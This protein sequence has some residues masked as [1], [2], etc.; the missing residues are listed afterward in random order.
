MWKTRN[1]MNIQ[2]T[3]ENIAKGLQIV[4]RVA[5]TKS[6]LPILGNIL[7]QTEDG[8]LKLAATDLELGVTTFVRAKVEEEGSITLPAR[9]LVDFLANATDPTLTIRTKDQ[10]ASIQSEHYQATLKGM[11]ASEFPLI[12]AVK[13]ATTLT[14]ESAAFR[15]ALQD[16]LF[17]AAVDDT[18]PVL[19]GVC[20]V[21]ADRQLTLAATDSY[22]LAER[23]VALAE[24]ATG[25]AIIPSRT[26][27][28]L[29]RILPETDASVTVAL[30]ENQLAL[31]LEETSIVSRLIEGTF[32]N[33]SQIIPSDASTMVTL[34]RT[35]LLNAVKVASFFARDT[36]HNVRV[37]VEPPTTFGIH[38][39]SAAVGENTTNIP[40]QISGE[41]V[42]IAFNAKYLLDAINAIRSES[43][44]LEFSGVDRPGVLHPVG[45]DQYLS[46][47]MPLRVDS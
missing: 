32:P 22:R 24:S 12:P 8:Q 13:E 40:A 14:I 33:Y 7:L 9:L 1:L 46:L 10:E 43:V 15:R 11:D 25:T 5:T 36:A 28:E 3:Q 16:V 38:A 17:A 19:N 6:S 21:A 27:A 47:V 45:D 30:A 41:A 29:A 26:A 31:S 2:C 42:S 20:L 37:V 18:R 44:Q 4:S 34:D 35:E 39:V 23:R